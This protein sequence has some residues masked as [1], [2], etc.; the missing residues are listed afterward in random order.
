[1]APGETSPEKKKQI[2][3]GVYF[4]LLIFALVVL[5]VTRYF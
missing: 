2:V 3:L 5:I 4:W 1:L